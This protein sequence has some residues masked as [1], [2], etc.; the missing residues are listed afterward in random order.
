MPYNSSNLIEPVINLMVSQLFKS[1][2]STNPRG[3]IIFLTTLSN[4]PKETRI[5]AEN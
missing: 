3:E 2:G 1:V 5:L 4:H